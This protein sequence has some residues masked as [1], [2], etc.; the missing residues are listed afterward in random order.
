MGEQ[1]GQRWRERERGN[2]TRGM[3]DEDGQAGEEGMEEVLG[4]PRQ[5]Q[6]GLCH[7]RVIGW[8]HTAPCR[9]LP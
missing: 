4:R 7:G 6:V 8:V 5:G 9:D 3:G 1:E 2:L